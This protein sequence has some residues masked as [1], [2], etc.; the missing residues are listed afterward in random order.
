MDNIKEL[1]LKI[2]AS[3]LTIAEARENLEIAKESKNF[4]RINHYEFV[5]NM[6]QEKIRSM[7]ELIQM[8]S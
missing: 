3:N 5:I 4:D 1:K 6:H 7:N 2:E 8:H